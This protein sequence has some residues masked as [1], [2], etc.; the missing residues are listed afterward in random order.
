[1][2][3]RFH[4]SHDRLLVIEAQL[5]RQLAALTQPNMH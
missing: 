3:L 5:D 4:L 1:V 2:S